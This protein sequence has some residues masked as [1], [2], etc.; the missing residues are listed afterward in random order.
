LAKQKRGSFLGVFVNWAWRHRKDLER[1]RRKAMS[2]ETRIERE[3]ERERERKRERERE[4]V[5]QKQAE[6]D[7]S[8]PL[9]A[10]Q[11]E[12]FWMEV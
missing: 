1:W 5:H 9:D 2:V 4:A 6:G 7:R 11:D 12:V 3:R 8:G 10:R